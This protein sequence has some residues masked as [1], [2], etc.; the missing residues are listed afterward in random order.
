MEGWVRPGPG[1]KEHYWPTVAT[2]QPA[3]DKRLKVLGLLSHEQRRLCE[4]LIEAY[5]ILNGKDIVDKATFFQ[6][7]P[8]VST[9]RGHNMKLFI[10][11]A[12]L[13]YMYGSIS[14]V[15]EWFH[16]G[17]V[18]HNMMSMHTP[19]VSSFK[20]RL[21][22]YWHDMDVKSRWASWSIN[23]QVQVQ[24]QVQPADS[25][26][27]HRGRW[28]SALTTRPSR[29][30]EHSYQNMPVIYC[31]SVVTRISSDGYSCAENGLATLQRAHDRRWQRPSHRLDGTR[32]WKRKQA[33][34]HLP[35]HSHLLTL[36][37]TVIMTLTL[38]RQLLLYGPGTA[39]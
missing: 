35:T 21:N 9:L 26:P 2:R 7:S 36:L 29:H 1:C 19:S 34:A 24:V 4:D 22:K 23:Y 14:S 30:P 17:I 25:N 38:W 13:G 12:T 5:K 8:P 37:F 20:S 6:L 10:P 16:T 11:R 31:A 15:T 33:P 39:I 3:A 28:L 18:C 27:R 32:R